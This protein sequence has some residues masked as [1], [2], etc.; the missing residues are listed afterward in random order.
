MTTKAQTTKAEISK[1]DYLKL[2]SFCTAN[3]IINKMK[4]QPIDWEKIFTN[5][6]CNMGL[7]SKICKKLLN[8]I[9]KKQQSD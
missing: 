7:I 5:P 3:E 1:W 2:K 4:I 6:L 9:A 8:S